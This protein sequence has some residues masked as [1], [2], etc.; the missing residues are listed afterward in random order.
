M[1]FFVAFI[2]LFFFITGVHA[3][4]SK[5]QTE[6]QFQNWLQKTLW[7]KAR[8]KGISSTTF[9]AVFQGI[10]L[11]WALPDLVPPGTKPPVSQAQHQAE[12]SPPENYFKN[13]AAIVN[14]GK[15]RIS[16][17]RAV[18]NSIEKKY[19]V[20]AGI[21]VAIW[22]RESAFGTVKIPHNAFTVLATKAFMSTRKDMFEAEL[23]AALEIVQKGYM[24]APS[25][26]SSWA[27]ALGQ[28]QF[29]PTSYLQ[30]AVDFDKDGHRNIWTSTP[31]TLA[32]IAAFL[33]R[34][35]WQRSTNWG[36]EVHLPQTL[37]CAL[38]GPDQGRSLTDWK[39]MGVTRA[40]GGQMTNLGEKSYL[41]L[42]AG[43]FGPTFLV[44]DNFYV[45]KD[46][47]MSDLYALF[48]GHAADMMAGG[49]PFKTAW[50]KTDIM[51][52]SDIANLQK[53]L[54]TE[55]Y[56]VGKADGLAG[57]KTR[58]SIGLWQQKNSLT[59]TCFPTNSL[60]MRLR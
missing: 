41:L 24:D 53:K 33:E 6:Q 21:I 48:I 60:I 26:K 59:P 10:T 30:Y 12:F 19:G 55:G 3:A 8:Q 22:G 28:P 42:P 46:Y 56:D 35:G 20:P 1:R 25:M 37:S 58:R 39:R 50:K 45:L 7:P 5:A 54:Q 23:L 34:H 40:D 4:P 14:G 11:N 31:D 43:R 38:E 17:N 44:S 13:I 9:S 52:R 18:L 32:S 47:N 29:M 36:Y 51:L 27:G 57:F 49:A 16:Q 15:I 2:T